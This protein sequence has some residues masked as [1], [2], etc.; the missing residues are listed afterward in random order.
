VRHRVEADRLT[1]EWMVARFAAQGFSEAI[2]DW[3]HFG[4]GGLRRGLARER[5]AITHHLQRRGRS[6]LRVAG[7]RAALAA[8]RRGAIYAL[9]A[10][11][12]WSPAAGS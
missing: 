3:K 2:V 4:A 6:D 1:P 10:V 7:H 5:A 8:Y 12:R 11:A 9:W